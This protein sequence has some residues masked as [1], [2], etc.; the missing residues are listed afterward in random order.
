MPSAGASLS[1]GVRVIKLGSRKFVCA[2]ISDAHNLTEG[3][4]EVREIFLASN[5]EG[6]R[7]NPEF[8]VCGI[9]FTWS[10]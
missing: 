8:F 1:H 10:F 9:Q 7:A 4:Y 6:G 3:E 5:T 2:R